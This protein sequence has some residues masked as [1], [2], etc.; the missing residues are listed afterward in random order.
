VEF[1]C[2][3][4]VRFARA[5]NR[6]TS[7]VL[8]QVRNLSVHFRAPG[9]ALPALDGVDVDVAP[10]RTTALVGE[11]GSGKSLTALAVAGLLP[12]TAEVTAGAIALSGVDLRALSPARM[13]AVRGARLAMIFQDPSTA[14]N[15]VVRVGEQVVEAIRVHRPVGRAAARARAAELFARVGIPAPAARLRAFPHE[16][17]GGMR[18]RVMIAMALSCAPEL[19]IADEPTTALDVTIQAQILAL[20]RGLQAEHGMGMLFITHDLG[21]VA[22]I[23]DEVSVMYAGRIVERG[24]ADAVFA[25]PAHPYTRA[26]LRGV[27]RLA[28]GQDAPARGALPV[29]AGEVPT[30]ASR[31]SGCA[32]HPR[33]A[34]MQGDPVC[35][36]TPPPLEPVGENHACACWHAPSRS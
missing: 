6:Y 9:G 7:R 12:S 2:A 22:Q 18:Q 31:P 28:A 32:F 30:L 14:L 13:R 4:R 11:S 36:D 3:A 15:P 33:C 24:P 29:I 35:R 34:A 1:S 8:L 16:L 27:P 19:L 21:V 5:S 26:L 10:G 23:A 17:S 20:L 25:R